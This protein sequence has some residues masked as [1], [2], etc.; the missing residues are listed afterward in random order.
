MLEELLANVELHLERGFQ[1]NPNDS[2]L[3]SSEA[4]L[5]ELLNE[6]DEALNALRSGFAA[7]PRDSYLA[8]RL[9]KAHE[10]REDLN[11]AL[12]VIDLGLKAD[13]SNKRLNYRKAMILRK[14]GEADPELFVYYL[15]RAFTPGDDN[16]EAL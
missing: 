16:Y 13:R 2:Y 1:K 9:A 8:I 5:R 7:N 3:T 14:Q 10:F 11:E 15:R 6:S 4:D 12:H